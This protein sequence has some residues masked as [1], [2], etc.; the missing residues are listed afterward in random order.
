MKKQY[1]GSKDAKYYEAALKQNALDMTPAI[2]SV[3]GD[4]GAKQPITN[5]RRISSKRSKQTIKTASTR[6]KQRRKSSSKTSQVS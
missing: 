6:Q 1:D 5:T 4:E 2:A 3:Y